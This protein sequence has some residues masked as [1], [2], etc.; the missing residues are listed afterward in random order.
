[1]KCENCNKEHDGSYGSG[2][3]CSSK[4][5]RGFSTKAKRKEINEKVSKKLKGKPFSGTTYT[6]GWP[7]SAGRKG[8]E[9]QKRAR[10]MIYDSN[11]YELM[12]HSQIKRKVKEEQKGKC[13]NCGNSEWLG[14]PIY[15]EIHHKD[16][17]KKNNDRDNL[18]ALCLNCHQ[19][20]EKYRFKGR[21]HRGVA[22]SG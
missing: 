9:S 15:L 10:Q 4:C 14:K 13:N 17:N 2:R 12:S 3:F 19:Q 5:A 6:G 20:T 1:M 22:Q 16:N 18:E 11:K 21:K 8:N 7:A